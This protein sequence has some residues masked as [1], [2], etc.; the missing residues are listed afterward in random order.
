[1]GKDTA[2]FSRFFIFLFTRPWP[3]HERCTKTTSF[4]S[5]HFP[6]NLQSFFFLFQFK[7]GRRI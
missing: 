2:H 4:P 3:Y 6:F 1:M 5:I 7:T